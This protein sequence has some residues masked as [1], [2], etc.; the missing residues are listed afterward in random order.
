MNPDNYGDG[1]MR[2]A[3][4]QRSESQ[5]RIVFHSPLP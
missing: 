3:S 1:G 4:S 5:Q 2:V